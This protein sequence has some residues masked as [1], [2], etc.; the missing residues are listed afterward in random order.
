MSV[1]RKHILPFF[2]PHLGCPNQCVFCDQRQISGRQTAP[3]PADLAALLNSL[4]AEEEPKAELAFYGGSFTAIPTSAQEAFL[5]IAAEAVRQHKIASIRISTRPD[6]VDDTV[7]GLLRRYG[8]N[9]VEL[10]V[11]SMDDSVL[12]AARRGHKAADSVAA[13]RRLKRVGFCTGVQLMPGLPGETVKS[14]ISGAE[15]ILAEKPDL[16]RIYPTVVLR[17][18]ELAGR[19]VRGEY[20]PLGL[21]EAAGV[22]LY[23]KLLAEE[24]GTRVIRIGLQ[25]SEELAAQVLAGPYHPAFGEL[26]L[27]LYC[28]S[29]ALHL[30]QE[31]ATGTD[32]IRPKSGTLYC[33]EKD[34]SAVIGQKKQNIAYYKDI[35]PDLQIKPAALPPGELRLN[36]DGGVWRLTD[37]QFRQNWRQSDFFAPRLP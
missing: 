7:I 34:I 5:R 23:I 11:Q 1:A 27:G 4:P 17:G 9:T 29:K 16:L 13:V 21:A 32:N 22:S 8:V 24:Q 10:G 30:L 14:A 25:P 20:A 3:T 36:I 12:Q 33:S 15:R 2:I 26:V 35:L 31:A 18:T 28:R 6:C 37:G 19:F